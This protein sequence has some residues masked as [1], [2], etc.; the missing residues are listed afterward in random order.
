MVEGLFVNNLLTIFVSF[1][2]ILLI[3]SDVRNS[4]FLLN[5]VKSQSN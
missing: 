2:Y 3:Q 5:V 1:V 4:S